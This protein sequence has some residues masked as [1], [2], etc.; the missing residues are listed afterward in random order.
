MQATLLQTQD[1][2]VTTGVSAGGTAGQ[3]AL[4]SS[5]VTNNVLPNNE[6]ATQPITFTDPVPAGFTV[7]SAGAGGGL[8]STSGQTVTCTVSLSAG[9]SAPVDV[10]VTPSAAGS[11]T[12]AVSVALP[13]DD[14]DPTPANNSATATLSVAPALVFPSSP[15]PAPVGPSSVGPSPI[16][17]SGQTHCV[18]PK[19]KGVSESFAK[20][21]LKDLG[22]K[23]KVKHKHSSV[24]KGDVIGT[25]PGAGTY[26]DQTT[27]TVKV[28]SGKKKKH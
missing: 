23:V 10:L 11:Y 4:L 26:A 6:S 12:N 18:V 17:S 27:V 28:S 25:S 3:V 20:T 5:T 21:A 14:T 24:H 8:C 7:D 1:A 9:Q 15:A 2:A 22:C 16:G 19:L 13:V